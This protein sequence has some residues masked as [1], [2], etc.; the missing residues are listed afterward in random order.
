MYKLHKSF[1]P[2]T[3]ISA[4]VWR[5]ISFG[6]LVWLIAQEKLYFSRLDQH[7]DG[8]EGFI[9][10]NW[11]KGKSRYIRFTTY[12]NCW[13]M[14]GSESD[15]MWKCYGNPHGE[16]VAIKTTVGRLIKSIEKS[17]IDTFIGEIDYTESESSATNLYTPVLFKRKAFIHEQELRLCVSSD[18]CDNPPYFSPVIQQA[19]ALGC[20]IAETE[21]LKAAGEKGGSVTVDLAQLV[22]EVVLCPNRKPWLKEAVEYVVKSKLSRVRISE[23]MIKQDAVCPQENA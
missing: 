8:W 19:N 3:D 10:R 17:P 13:H 20:Q 6:Q 22:E 21:L 15:D 11:D 5:Y 16:T 12:I 1:N 2:L 14:N 18:S 4:M 9:P 23:S 7:E